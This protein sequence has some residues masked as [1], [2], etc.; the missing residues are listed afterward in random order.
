MTE[1]RST[2]LLEARPLKGEAWHAD[3]VRSTVM[4][5]ASYVLL[6]RERVEPL[7]P[8]PLIPAAVRQANVIRQHAPQQLEE[9]GLTA[10]TTSHSELDLPTQET[11]SV[12]KQGACLTVNRVETEGATLLAPKVLAE[13][14]ALRGSSG[15]NAARVYAIM[16]RLAS[17]YRSQGY[18]ASGRGASPESTI[19]SSGLPLKVVEGKGFNKTSA[20]S[21]RAVRPCPP[22]AY[23][24]RTLTSSVLNREQKNLIALQSGRRPSPVSQYDCYGPT[25]RRVGRARRRGTLRRA[26]MSIGINQKVV[27]YY[28][29]EISISIK[30][31]DTSTF[32]SRVSDLGVLA[33][34]SIFKDAEISREIPWTNMI[35]LGSIE[36]G[37]HVFPLRFHI[38]V[39]YSRLFRHKT[40]DSDGHI[41]SLITGFS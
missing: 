10:D 12:A 21:A 39:D 14:I 24:R 20:T 2:D 33:S 30:G 9:A 26:A 8:A 29:K 35:G 38:D 7:R 25:A 22:S 18:A 41:V 5:A 31:N 27:C 40:E 16:R 34:G 13:I 11:R 3:A 6:P 23:G 28:L 1:N 36:I 37:S 15:L 19:R 32:S 17:L 4:S